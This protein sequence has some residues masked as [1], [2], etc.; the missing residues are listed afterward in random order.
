V[1]LL[2]ANRIRRLVER[3][4]RTADARPASRAGFHPYP[5]STSERLEADVLD[6][7]DHVATLDVDADEGLAGQERGCVA[8]VNS[9]LGDLEVEDYVEPTVAIDVLEVP[10]PMCLTAVP[11]AR[12]LG[13][14]EAH[15]CGIDG[16]GVEASSGDDRDRH[17]APC[18]CVDRVGVTAGLM[19]ISTSRLPA[20]VFQNGDVV[21]VQIGDGQVGLAIPV[22]VAHRYRER[23]AC[24]H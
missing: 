19:S 15:A 14:A 13:I 4:W 24:G 21:P 9:G 8:R 2:T 10:L 12:I 20:V 3:G 7:R 22:Q 6:D 16:R 23:F 17:Q 1:R 18:A 11:L 5:P